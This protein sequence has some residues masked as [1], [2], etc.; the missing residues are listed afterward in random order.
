MVWVMGPVV[1]ANIV[2]NVVFIPMWGVKGAAFT[3]SLTYTLGSVGMVWVYSRVTGLS[4]REILTPR[5]SD[6]ILKI[7]RG[8][9]RPKPDAPAEN[10]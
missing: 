3:S 6:F 10:G 7:R 5:R 2:L 9:G 1:I 8:R 4:L